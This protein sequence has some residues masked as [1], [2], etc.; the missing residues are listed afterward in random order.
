MLKQGVLTRGRVAYWKLFFDAL[1]QYPRAFGTAITL[2]MMG[3]HLQVIT[4]R[5]C[6]QSE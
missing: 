2:A 5:V 3:Y 6:G 4:E 1:T